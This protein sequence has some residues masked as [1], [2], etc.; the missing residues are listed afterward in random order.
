MRKSIFHA[1]RIS[2]EQRRKLRKALAGVPPGLG[3]HDIYRAKAAQEG[4]SWILEISGFSKDERKTIALTLDAMGV[5]PTEPTRSYG[6]RVRRVAHQLGELNRMGV[7]PSQVLE[8][9]GFEKEEAQ[10]LA[11]RALRPLVPLIGARLRALKA[12]L[13]Q[14]ERLGLAEWV[15]KLN[16]LEVERQISILDR[17]RTTLQKYLA[18]TARLTWPRRRFEI[19]PQ[20]HRLVDLFLKAEWSHR[21]AYRQT[22]QFLCAWN[23]DRGPTLT[24]DLVRVRYQK[25]RRPPR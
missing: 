1:P 8:A 6:Q 24:A 22:A 19:S 25:F 4:A 17:G 10:R 21:Q 5:D 11:A 12:F 13:R 18:Q 20:V 7:E 23:A 15:V 14:A 2:G 9:V 16:G 3:F